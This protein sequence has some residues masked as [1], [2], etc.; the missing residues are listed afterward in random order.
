[1]G[2]YWLLH[3]TW[4]FSD[5][6]FLWLRFFSLIHLGFLLSFNA[7]SFWVTSKS[8]LCV[9][10]G[11]GNISTVSLLPYCTTLIDTNHI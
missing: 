4:S 1:M 3:L 5:G 6:F 7:F 11:L 2:L 8:Y 10:L 9:F